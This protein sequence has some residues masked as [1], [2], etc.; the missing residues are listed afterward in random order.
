MTRIQWKICKIVNL[1]Y[2]RKLS[3]AN[4][5]NLT[6]KNLLV[7]L[8]KSIELGRFHEVKKGEEVAV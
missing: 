5:S 4:R 7:I 3:K 8:I 2:F 6:Q 1:N